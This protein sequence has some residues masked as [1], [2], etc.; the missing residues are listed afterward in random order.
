[1]GTMAL[2]EWY[3]YLLYISCDVLQNLD[4]K[5]VAALVLFYLQT[6]LRLAFSVPDL[7][8]S[9][10]V[11]RLLLQYQDQY[12]SWLLQSSFYILHVMYLNTWKTKFKW[13]SSFLPPNIS[14]F[15]SF[16]AIFWEFWSGQR[17]FWQSQAKMVSL[18]RA[19]PPCVSWYQLLFHL[20][21]WICR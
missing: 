2:S 4:K 5:I 7:C 10:V 8:H 3:K 15:T 6:Y 1:M 9:G 21:W 17:T 18:K 16:V 19:K 11:N 12:T 14:Q 13:C 20:S